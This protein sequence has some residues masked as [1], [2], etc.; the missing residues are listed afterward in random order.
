MMRRRKGDRAD[1]VLRHHG[2]PLVFI[3]MGGLRARLVRG[4]RGWPGLPKG[5]TTWNPENDPWELYCN[6]DEDWAKSNDLAAKMP[7]KV[8]LHEKPFSRRGREE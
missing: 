6:L 8:R 7:G 3:M 2:Q 4:H 1:A 5:I